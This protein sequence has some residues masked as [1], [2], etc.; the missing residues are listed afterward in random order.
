MRNT[1]L[2]FFLVFMTAMPTLTSNTEAEISSQTPLSQLVANRFG[3]L[4]LAEERLVNAA[5]SGETADCNNLS[6]EDRVIRGEL[7]A[8]LCTNPNASA[9]LTYRGVS[10][11]GAEIDNKT[12]L[13]WAKIPFPIRL[14]RCVFRDAIIL[15]HGQ[16]ASL[17]L[18]GSSVQELQ[19]VLTHFEG[20]LYL[21]DGFKA[22][23][24]VSLTAA[25]IDENL[26]CDGGAFINTGEKL[27]L[28]ANGIEVKGGVFLRKGFRAEGGV[29]L[30]A[31]KIGRT[32]E[33]DG[34][35]I[36]GK[37][38]TPALDANSV[39]VNG[40]VFLRNG[41][42]S[43][44]GV[45]FRVARIGRTL[46]CGGG[47]FISKSQTPALDVNGAE[48]NGNVYLYNGFYADGGVNLVGAKIDR[49][50][51]CDSGRIVGKGET[52]ALDANN[53][54][55]K[56]SIF[57]RYGFK[58][59]G[60]VDLGSAHIEG[61]LSCTGSQFISKGKWPALNT[62]GVEVKGRVLLRD[63]FRAEGGV[64]LVRAKID[65][66]LECHGGQFIG[67]DR[68]LALNAYIAEVKGTVY[69]GN[70]FKAEGGVNLFGAKIDGNL[71]CD[72]GQFI[73]NDKVLA[74]NARGVVVKGGVA[75]R[76]VRAEGGVDLTRAK[77]DGDLTC[78]GGEFISKGETPALDANG[79]EVNGNVYLRNGFKAEGEV[80]LVRAKIDGDLDCHGGEFIGKGQKPALDAYNARIDGSVYFREE[81]VGEGEIRFLGAYVGSNF[82][83]SEVK[84][85]EK[86]ILDLRRA[87]VGTLLNSRSSWPI[88][89]NLRIDGLVYDEIDDMAFPDAKVQL[90]WLQR[91]SKDRFLSQPFEQ[92]A[93]V[94]RKMGLEEDA[95]KVMIAKN[96]DQAAH[97]H[98][99]PAWLWYGFF[100]KLIGYGYRPSYAF[101]I[102]VGL[103]VIGCLL[104]KIGHNSKIVT[105]TE[106]KAFVVYVEKNGKGDHFERYPVFNSFI[107]S[108]E[109]FV[110]LLKLGISQYWMPNANSGLPVNFGIAVLPTGSLL[111]GY[112]WFHIVAGWVL[113]ALWVGAIT[114]LV[115]T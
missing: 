90:G 87:R 70:G 107:Y 50:L 33:C 26:N 86:A 83:W 64:S 20:G 8:W 19:A 3:K 109:T 43:E 84:F 44:G 51:V 115:K 75:L 110:P 56:G 54:K 11:T 96:K 114:G 27:A 76:W 102:S 36:I 49:N 98:W 85:P 14:V 39:E 6:G 23:G 32:L 67:N 2:G 106:E 45:I 63:R 13:E 65:G 99:S 59:E 28:N 29:N 17:D 77:I 72:R 73:G 68:A 30:V 69:L 16:I 15:S 79:V 101:G 82:Q 112:L 52:S 58:A 40:N 1:F 21:G 81:F 113:S 78:S 91:Q 7:L 9:Q 74:L 105:P 57:L 53:A 37:G 60:G 55:V 48:V 38:E 80:N 18:S 66:D 35:Q 94:L 22:E 108:V 12:D 62:D 89:G 46:E 104:F 25:K 93:A 95:R 97:L 92:L 24:E 10:I 31:A 34:A 41:F 103:I 88:K 4:S 5:A 111:R 100:G 61:D 71:D 42:K 47:Q